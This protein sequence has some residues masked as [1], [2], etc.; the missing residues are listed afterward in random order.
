MP[1]PYEEVVKA[2]SC[3]VDASWRIYA[4]DR[5]ENVNGFVMYILIDQAWFITTRQALNKMF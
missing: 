5:H 2:R 3:R 1:E 4:R